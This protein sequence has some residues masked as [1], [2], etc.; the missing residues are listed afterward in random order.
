MTLSD[1]LTYYKKY[2]TD[3]YFMRRV[4]EGK[5]AVSREGVVTN[6]RTGKSLGYP[7]GSVDKRYKVMGIKVDGSIKHVMVA[8]IVYL[9]HKGQIPPNHIVVYR[10]G[11]PMNTH[12]GS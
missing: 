9:T 6:T 5:Y 3:A 4:M 12:K 11:N 10:D 8:R 1:D 7:C 2:G